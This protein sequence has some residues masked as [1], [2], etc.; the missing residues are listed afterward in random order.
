M[1]QARII[2]WGTFLKTTFIFI[3]II[4]KILQIEWPQALI[5]C[6]APSFVTMIYAHTD[7][8]YDCSC[9]YLTST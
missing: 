9:T 6:L 8:Q 5:S 7:L 1:H 4:E 3:F 2:G